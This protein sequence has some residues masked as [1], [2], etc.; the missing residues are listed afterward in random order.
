[1]DAQTVVNKLTDHLL[2]EDW[3]IVD[4]VGGEQAN[5]IILD[6][7]ARRYPPVHESPANKWRRKHKRCKW[8]HHCKTRVHSDGLVTIC[9]AKEKLVDIDI[10]RPFC[11]VFELDTYAG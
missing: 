10:P 11:T 1:M 9:S 2:G 8:C 4:P 3:Y 5:E 6:T 7:I